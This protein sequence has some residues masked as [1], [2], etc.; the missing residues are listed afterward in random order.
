M[1][2]GLPVKMFVIINPSN[3]TGHVMSKEDLVAVKKSLSL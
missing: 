3:P 2:S 1:E